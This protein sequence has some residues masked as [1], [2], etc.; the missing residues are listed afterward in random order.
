MILIAT[1]LVAIRKNCMRL[2][3]DVCYHLITYINIVYDFYC[4]KVVDLV[5]PNTFKPHLV[6][7]SQIDTSE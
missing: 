2:F 1:S 7:L 4:I 5:L 6:F 3:L